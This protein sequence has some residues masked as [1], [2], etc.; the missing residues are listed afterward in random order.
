MWKIHVKSTKVSAH[1]SRVHSPTD[2]ITLATA[3]VSSIRSPT[4]G[5]TGGK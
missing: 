3:R 5:S 2:V 1:A 4:T